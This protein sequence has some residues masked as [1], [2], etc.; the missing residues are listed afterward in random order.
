[1][2]EEIRVRAF[3]PFFSTKG[4]RASGLGL[5]VAFGT[6]RAHGGFVELDSLP[7][8]GTLARLAF[9]RAPD[10]ALPAGPPEPPADPRTR[11]R[12]RE[13]VLVVDDDPIARAEARR[14]LEEFG[15]HVEV[16]ANTR[17]ALVRL[18]HKP[19]VDLVLLDMVLP[20]LN[21]P[22]ALARILKHWPGQRVLMI[23]P[24]RLHEQEELCLRHGAVGIHSR[25]LR[26]EDLPR[27]V[28]AALDG[29]PPVAP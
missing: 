15:Y 1:M 12:G 26:E 20:G 19:R 4:R 7:G 25:P 21:G 10:D 9:P 2:P 24:Y 13:T 18:R 6:V 11:W 27:A 8:R 22:E 16:A 14:A 23:S 5:T 29:P 28:R 17:E 3:E